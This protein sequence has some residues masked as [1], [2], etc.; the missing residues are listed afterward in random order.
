PSPGSEMRTATPRKE[1]SKSR[2]SPKSLRHR[3]TY[4]RKPF[5]RAR[6]KGTHYALL[7]SETLELTARHPAREEEPR[8]SRC[9]ICK[10]KL[11]STAKEAV[12]PSAEKNVKCITVSYVVDA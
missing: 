12:Q 9:E 5:R 2:Y 10:C 4:K 11:D 7:S 8:N 1:K 3:G 6:K